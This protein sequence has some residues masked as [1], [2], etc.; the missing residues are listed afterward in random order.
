MRMSKDEYEKIQKRRI[1]MNSRLGYPSGRGIKKPKPQ[2]KPEIVLAEEQMGLD[3]DVP[4]YG[5][6]GMKEQPPRMEVLYVPY[7]APSLN[8]IYAGVHWAVR[9]QHADAGHEAC[10]HLEIA[11]FK[12]PVSLIFIPVVGK[13]GIARDC[14]NYSY[15]AKIVEDG[16]VK[17]RILKDDSPKYVASITIEKP[18]Y[19]RSKPS[20]MKVV[21]TEEVKLMQFI[22]H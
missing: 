12:H 8:K 22:L 11:M 2:V 16:L 15:A 20:G 21:V 18:V 19:D 3:F 9:K 14:S 5:L 1:K 7:M 4:D 6:T 13:G 10:M 17:T